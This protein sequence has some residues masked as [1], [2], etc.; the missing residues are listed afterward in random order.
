MHKPALSVVVIAYDMPREIPRTILSLSPAMQVGV[1]HDDYEIILIDNGSTRKFDIEE[2]R[3]TGADLRVEEFAPGDPSPCRAINRGLAIARGKLCGV[4]IDGARLVSPGVVA[5]ALRAS[6]LHDRAV[7][8]TL[9]F[10]LG[11]DVQMRSVPL[12]YDQQ[13]EDRLLDSV[14]WTHD[15]YRLFDISVFAGS[16]VSGWF[17]PLSESNALFLTKKLWEELGGYDTRFRSPGGGLVNLDTYARACVLP[18]SQLIT[19]LGEGTFH[20]VHG[21]VATNAA[22][23]PWDM[24]QDEY[25]AIRGQPFAKPDAVP[26]F[27]GFVDRHVLPSIAR[28]VEGS[29]GQLGLEA[30]K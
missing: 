15:G 29:S 17:A 26:L 3:S 18:D 4:M 20:Q 27:L 14:E 23:H 24:F 8:S 11:P 2:C 9:G 1:S 28:S 19:L 21:G 25:L 16:S 5:G 12:G 30:M 22:V 13:E 10:H 6:L 7:I